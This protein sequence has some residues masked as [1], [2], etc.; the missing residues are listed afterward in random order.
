[1]MVDWPVATPGP[2]RCNINNLTHLVTE[3][4]IDLA[5]WEE[6]LRL[7]VH[8][9][10]HLRTDVDLISKPVS[11][12][13]ATDFSTVFMFDDL[14]GSKAGESGVSGV[15]PLVEE[16]VNAAWDFGSGRPLYRHRLLRVSG[17]YMVMNI[18]HHS[19]GD[20]T[21]GMLATGGILARYGALVAGRKVEVT[22]L[23]PRVS[24]EEMTGAVEV[25]GGQVKVARL[26]REKAERA[27][28]YRPVVQFS[29]EELADCQASA[30]PLNNTVWREGSA[31]SYLAVRARCR[32]Q[33]V[34]VGSLVLA[35]TYLAHGV[36]VAL[37]KGV[38]PQLPGV[39]VDLPVNIRQNMTPA[40][41]DEYCGLYITEITTTA[42]IGPESS[43][44]GL[45]R[46]LGAQVKQRLAAQ[47]H[48]V[49]SA[50]KEQFETGSETAALANAVQPPHVL[51]VLVSNMRVVPFSLSQDW[52]ATVR[53]VHTAGSFWAPGFANYL[54]LVQSTN[55]FTYNM[56]HCP[57]TA[58]SATARRIL[59]TVVQLVEEVAVGEE[60]PSLRKL[61][62]TWWQADL[63]TT[64]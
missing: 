64:L 53:A 41:G 49:F 8:H 40:M 45:A 62:E 33:G 34:T 16:E 27:R 31:S 48:V 5:L 55:M 4:E 1:M 9:E 57:G 52:G 36:Q 17:G 43:L 21:T 42:D 37:D 23:E 13:P 24:V 59:D 58:N 63:E 51:D 2:R 11:W 15:W 46:V 6:A 30:L 7:T 3:G 60:D 26:V 20:G 39:L 35:A 56:V 32:E 50:V 14:R 28:H 25:E 44:W 38:L 19:A 61:M 54:L 12:I 10:P 22:A 47:E 18:Y 29:T